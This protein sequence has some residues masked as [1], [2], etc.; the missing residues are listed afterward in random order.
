MKFKIV[1]FLLFF[2]NYIYSQNTNCLDASTDASIN[3]S[4]CQGN[5]APFCTGFDTPFCN[6]NPSNGGTPQAQSGIDYSTVRG[7]G[8][9]S[10]DSWPYPT[11][12]FIKI[13]NP[14]NLI[15][16]ISQ[17][18]DTND[19]GINDVGESKQDVDFICWG[20]FNTSDITCD[21]S[22]LTNANKVDGSWEAFST[23]TMTIN[24]AISGE[25]YI[26][27]IS[28][29]DSQKGVISLTQTNQDASNAAS[30][31]CSIIAGNLG[32]DQEIC[33]GTNVTLDGTPTSGT[34]DTYQ[35]FL[36]TGAGFNALAGE[37]NAILEITNN[38]SG[39]YKVEITDTNGNVGN[40]DVVITFFKTPIANKPTD[41]NYCD[42]DRDGFNAFNLNTDVT[43]LVLLTQST[44]EFEVLY[45]KSL[46][47]ANANIAGTNLPN[48]YTNPTA[49]SSET[50]YARTHN[51]NLP[52]TCF[53]ITDFT[54]FVNDL[55]VVTQPEP[56]RICDNTQSTSDTDGIVNTFLLNTK[57]SEIYGALDITKYTISY[58]TTATGAD[59][60]D[61]STIIDK[62]AN[63]SVT[64]SQNVFIRLENN[65]NTACYDASKILELI[66]DPLPVV[67]NPVEIR[68]CV[69]TSDGKTTINLTTAQN[70]I[71]STPNVTFEFYEDI[72]TTTQ[73]LNFTTYPVDANTNPPKSVYV[74]TISE[75]GCPRISELKLIIGT[76][77]D[78]T[79]N[80]TFTVC[81]DLLDADGNDTANN[82]DTDGITQF[83]LDKNYIDGNINTNPNIDVF[84]YENETDRAN[85]LNAIDITNYR[86]K[87]IPNT[88]GSSFPIYYKLVNKINNDCQGLGEINL[89]VKQV[90]IAITPSNFDLCDDSFSG[91]TID[92]ENINI[93][94]RDK[95]AEILGTTQSETNYI[96][97]FHTTA[98]GATNNTD[99][100]PNDG[101]NFRN[102]AQAGFSAGDISEQTIYVRVEDR[103]NSTLQCKN[104]N[105]SFKVIVNPLPIVTTT[106][107]PL[108]FC[109][110]VTTTDADPRNRVVQNVDLTAKSIEILD[111]K[112]DHSVVYYTSQQDA[113]DDTN[114]IA[115][116]SNFESDAALTSFPANFNSDEP[117]IQTIFFVIKENTGN[118]CRS[119][120]STFQLIIYPEPNIPA[121]ILEYSDCD[122]ESDSET[123]DQNG[124]NGDISLESKTAE[125]LV[126]YLP[127]E[128]ANFNITFYTSFADADS[129]D[130]TLAID[131]NKYQ[132]TVNNETIFVRVHNTITNCVH[133]GLSFNINIKPLPNFTVQG[134]E[135][136]DDPQILCLNNSPLTLFT[137]NPDAIYNYQWTDEANTDLGNTS[138]LNVTSAGKYTVT[139]SDQFPDGCSRSKTI[140]VVESNVATLTDSNVIIVD[141]SNAISNQESLSVL[142]DTRNN[143]LGPGD[144][145][146]AILNN[147]NGTRIPFVGFKDEPL[148]ENLEGGIYTIIVNDKN[149][150]Q[151]DTTLQISVLQFPKFMTPNS[152][153]KNDT[154]RVKGVSKAFFSDASINIFDRFGKLIA[155]LPIDSQGWNGTYNGK[156]MASTDYWYNVTLIPIKEPKIPIKKVGHFSLLRK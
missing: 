115:N 82:D 112:T 60:N 32:P 74:K 98:N 34:P 39:T 48:P 124:I 29:F 53:A 99:I 18:S 100:I 11:W 102:T 52:N 116:P 67:N 54:L 114:A 79:Y 108:P 153:A 91:T 143:I 89:I 147:D 19:N 76:A 9:S 136:I 58:H 24:G 84:Y 141:E 154:W 87:N 12:F 45:F 57:D 55:P 50:I 145:Q 121:S 142:I 70:N 93:N 2:S 59:T 105:T 5:L 65:D 72:T 152:D 137:E 125:I 51:K 83:N 128:Y 77:S 23:E 150:C 133:T 78:V 155:Q 17:W 156:I 97:S 6:S 126:R 14:G 88:T 107:T 96:V 140:V 37:T 120:F 131:K 73:I 33:F 4:L 130:T 3:T 110:I 75:F 56:Y 138:T 113:I 90:P 80:E 68:Q 151:P 8:P 46:A 94:L 118:Q 66:V 30:T 62:N 61:A 92:G 28:N 44:T 38:V 134:E 119:V 111:G 86:N 129:G 1:F 139:A 47:D 109:D 71:S 95:V 10:P 123:S 146:F 16:D 122:N 106:I 81:D 36:D 132:N 103:D 20:P 43:P 101:T 7:S 63:H 144:Y 21:P 149:G 27:M 25:I 22:N 49:F 42:S 31:D 117:G 85:T 69:N 64:N 15:V 35:W 13:D 135:N 127:S 41:I 40:D 26:L 148:F 104:A